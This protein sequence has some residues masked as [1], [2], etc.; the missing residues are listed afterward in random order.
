M[1][2]LS[3]WTFNASTSITFLSHTHAHN[4]RYTIRERTQ[5]QCVIREWDSNAKANSRQIEK[6]YI[7]Y[8]WKLENKLQLLFSI[9]RFI[10]IVCAV[11][12]W[13]IVI[14]M[15]HDKSRTIARNCSWTSIMDT[16][17]NDR[18][19]SNCELKCKWYTQCANKEKNNGQQMKNEIVDVSK[20]F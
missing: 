17:S 7:L 20:L 12:E 11:T 9:E 4:T 5:C 8:W 10:L 2:V 18:T 6:K 16:I 19:K 15:V 13:K 14:S 3:I 1:R